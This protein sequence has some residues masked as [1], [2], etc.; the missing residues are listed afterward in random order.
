MSRERFGALSTFSPDELERRSGVPLIASLR[1]AIRDRD[2]AVLDPA[3][4]APLP[5]KK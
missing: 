3:K 1:P 2:N 5:D 4:F